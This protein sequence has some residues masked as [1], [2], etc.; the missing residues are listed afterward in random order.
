[1]SARSADRHEQYVAAAMRRLV[2]AHE[3]GEMPTAAYRARRRQ[4]LEALA[5]GQL[6][7]RQAPPDEM[8][9]PRRVLAWLAAAVLCAIVVLLAV[10]WWL[11]G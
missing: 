11:P 5:R 8:P 7:L 1:M 4:L 2:D 9:A 10:L 6:P 3:S